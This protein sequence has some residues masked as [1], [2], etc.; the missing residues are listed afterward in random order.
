MYTPE[1]SY[2]DFLKGEQ[3]KYPKLNLKDIEVLK[4]RCKANEE[5]SIVPGIYNFIH[6][7]LSL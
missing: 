2:E 5:L 7:K 1:T 3:E 6:S 4:E